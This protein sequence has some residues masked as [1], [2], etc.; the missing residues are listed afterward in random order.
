MKRIY[1]KYK[2]GFTLFELLLVLVL[3]TLLGGYGIKQYIHNQYL[4]DI[5]AFQ[6]EINNGKND[7]I[8][9]AVYSFSINENS[10]SG[11]TD[12]YNTF[13]G[14]SATRLYKCMKWEDTHVLAQNI[15]LE[16]RKLTGT[17]LM[18]KYGGCLISLRVSPD[19]NQRFD[20]FFDCSEVQNYVNAKQMH[21]L[22]EAIISSL[23]KDATG[24]AININPR[25]QSL[26]G[27]NDTVPNPLSPYPTDEVDG[28]V[29]ARFK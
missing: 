24:F 8:L 29:A 7:D 1:V 19:N 18:D 28:K 25:A 6:E 22:E 27:A 10:E 5:F 2:N 20:I 14:L 16:N 3:I 26:L 12:E 21:L 11:C 9:S 15:L 4:D 23:S 17:G 13:R